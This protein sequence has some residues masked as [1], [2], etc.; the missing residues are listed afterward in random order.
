MRKSVLIVLLTLLVT[1]LAVAQFAPANPP[2][3][4]QTPQ[5]QMKPIGDPA[6]KPVDF[7]VFSAPVGTP[8]NGF[9]D[10]GQTMTYL[11]YPLRHQAC[12]ELG[13]G[14]G[15]PHQ[16]P[17]TH[18]MEAG[19]D[20]MN[21]QDANVFS[22]KDFTTPNGVFAIWM[23]VPHHGASGSS[24]DF[25]LGPIMPNTLF[26]LHIV[27]ETYRNNKL[28]DAYLGDFYVPKLDNNLSCPFNVDGWSHVPVFFADTSSFGPGGPL[29][30]H[31][32]Y[33]VT[34]TDVTGEGWSITTSFTVR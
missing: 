34:V 32:E 4:K 7:H 8:D 9:A 17:Y 15:D 33:R 20:I 1:T 22:A 29:Q 28:W 5:V 16:P 2:E 25:G 19:L 3:G 6:W 12:A 11:L 24:P 21:Y 23:I 18:E 26:P 13:R 31:Y 27:G 10:F 14:P 30:G